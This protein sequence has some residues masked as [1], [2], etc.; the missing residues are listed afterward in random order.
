MKKAE[1]I[2]RDKIASILKNLKQSEYPVIYDFIQTTNGYKRIEDMMI[3]LFIKDDIS[4]KAT[5]TH[6]EN[7]L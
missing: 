7:M 1:K 3:N 6:I 4:L 5:L 2:L